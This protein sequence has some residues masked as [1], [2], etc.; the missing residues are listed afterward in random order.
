MTTRAT[1]TLLGQQAFGAQLTQYAV[2][3]TNGGQGGWANDLTQWLNNQAYVSKQV[4]AITMEAPGFFQYMT[5]PDKWVEILRAFFETHVRTIEGLHSGIEAEFEEHPVG[6][7]GEVQHEVVNARR[8][9]SAPVVSVVDK[10]GLPFQNFFRSWIQY[11]M[12]DPDTKYALA[13]NLAT[14]PQAPWTADMFTTTVM[15]IEPDASHT[16]VVKA[17]L[18]TN[19][20]P[21][22]NGEED[23][24]RD[25]TAAGELLTLSIEFTALTQT[26]VGVKVLAQSLL[27]ALNMTNA[28]P[29]LR[30]A[31]IQAQDSDVAAA[32]DSYA[33]TLAE[34]A[35]TAITN[36]VSPGS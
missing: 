31:F 18:C 19:M 24:R 2:D 9:P 28:N 17:W 29:Y 10:I 8:T 30:P 12:M 35:D 21:H 25:L 3:P 16:R 27:S 20:M 4:F 26:G 23:G 34:V 6:G 1:A 33:A 7:A 22:S 11:G 5:D 14:S 32:P 13:T 15:F 36:P